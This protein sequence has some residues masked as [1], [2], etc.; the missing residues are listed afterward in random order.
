MTFVSRQPTPFRCYGFNVVREKRLFS[1][2]CA[3]NVKCQD[4]RH[5]LDVA[6]MDAFESAEVSNEVSYHIV[7]IG[8]NIV[9]RMGYAKARNCAC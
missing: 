5:F 6:K 3:N 9:V 2:V 7:S 4:Q 1:L 8:G